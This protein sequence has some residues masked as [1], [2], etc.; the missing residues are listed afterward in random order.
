MMISIAF[1]KSCKAPI[2]DVDVTK[3]DKLDFLSECA[4]G[5]KDGPGW[6][7]A[8]IDEGPRN[9]SRVRSV[10]CLGLDV[11][12]ASE[13]VIDPNTGEI[14]LDCHGD[15]IKRVAGVDPPPVDAMVAEIALH[16][17]NAVLHTTYGHLN[18]ATQPEGVEHPRYRLVFELSRPLQPDEL[19]LLSLYVAMRLGLGDSIDKQCIEV[20]RLF[21]FP[22]SPDEQRRSNFRY[23]EVAGSPLPVDVLL[24]DARSIEAAVQLARQSRPVDKPSTSVIEQFNHVGDIARLLEKHG[25]RAV[26]NGRWMAPGSTSQIAGVNLLPNSS[27]PLIY[28]HHANDVLADKKVH[29]AFDVFRILEHGGHLPAALTAAATQLGLK[30]S[31]GKPATNTTWDFDEKRP[32]PWFKEYASDMLANHHYRELSLAERG[33]LDTIRRECWVAGGK[34]ISADPAR[35]GR[36]TGFPVNEVAALLSP[37]LPLLHLDDSGYLY[38][39][40]LARQ[41]AENCLKRG[42][43]QLNGKVGGLKSAEMRRAAHTQSFGQANGSANAQANGQA[44]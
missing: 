23:E 35:L 7:P 32:P 18:P 43:L 20:S 28:S 34:G 37:I 5:P 31:S 26:S 36:L 38:D 29:D 13:S 21:Y 42:K 27:P 44:N 30:L 41:Y 11:E 1:V 15:A 6:L 8:E 33:L 10:S 24:T 12:A 22:R 17:W 9:S 25:Y 40:D 2:H 3:F 16:G 39:E 14:L 19:K 4:I